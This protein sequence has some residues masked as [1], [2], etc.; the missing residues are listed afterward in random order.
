VHNRDS[1]NLP[2]VSGGAT[3]IGNGVL[4][5][6]K[7]AHVVFCQFAPYNVFDAATNHDEQFNLRKTYRRSSFLLTRCWRIGWSRVHTNSER[8]HEPVEKAK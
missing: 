3:D 2:L 8:F 7:D 1:R 5:R 6:A 4:A